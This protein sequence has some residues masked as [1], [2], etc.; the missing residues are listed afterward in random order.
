LDNLAHSLA[1]AVIGETGLKRK[2]GLGM[3]TL[4]VAANLPD[5][6]VVGLA[7]GENL[8]FRRGWSHGPLGLLLLPPLL[9]GLMAGLDRWQARR[10]TRPPDRLRVHLGWLLALAYVGALSH[11]ALDLLNTYGVRCLA[12]FSDRWFYGD[13]LFIMDAWMWSVPALGV[14]LARRKWKRAAP[15]PGRPALAAILLTCGYIGAMAAASAVAED[16][17]RREAERQGLEVREVVANPVP[18]DVTRRRM[19]VATG[20]SYGFGEVR[21]RPLPEV[22]LSPELMPSNMDDPRLASLVRRKEVADYL[23]W[24]RLPFARFEADGQGT[25]LFLG[26]ARYMG[27]PAEGHLSVRTRLPPA[28]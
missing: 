26:D 1:G 24:S 13:T 14:W 8:A 12:P 17:T 3:A 2:T 5:I 19:V 28:E 16:L 20:G 23:F 10:G 21:W 25:V 18:L 22:T 15:N 11:P 7:F 9:A 6:D 27:T 4:I